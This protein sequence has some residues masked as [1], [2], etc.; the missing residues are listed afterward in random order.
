MAASVWSSPLSDSVSVWIDRSL[1]DTMPE[2]DVFVGTGNFLDLPELAGKWLELLHQATPRMTRVAV[3]WDPGTGDAQ[4]RAVETGARALG[5]VVQLFA[6]RQRGEL[7]AGVRLAAEARADAMVI[8]SSP[9]FS[10]PALQSIAGLAVRSRLPS[11]GL[12]PR[13]AEAGG[14]LAYGPNAVALYRQEAGIVAK[15]LKGARPADL[16]IVRPAR[17]ELVVNVRTAKQLGV[18]VPPE[19]LGR[20]DRIIE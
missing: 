18:V 13:Y 20:A 5:V 9:L 15:I 10:G 6:V 2:V 1:A 14:L 16:P 3:M 17:F 19:L 11:I 12:F 7:E 8:L 4:R